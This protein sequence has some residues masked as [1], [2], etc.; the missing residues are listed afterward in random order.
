MGVSILAEKINKILENE[1]Y[2]SYES[3]DLSSDSYPPRGGLRVDGRIVPSFHDGLVCGNGL[4][5]AYV[6]IRQH[7]NKIYTSSISHLNGPNYAIKHFDEECHLPPPSSLWDPWGVGSDYLD[8]RP[9][10]DLML[11]YNYNGKNRFLPAWD[12]KNKWLRRLRSTSVVVTEA[13]DDEIQLR[14]VNFAPLEPHLPCLI[15]IVCAKNLTKEK[16]SN[17][18]CYAGFTLYRNLQ[19]A[20][21]DSSKKVLLARAS[22]AEEWDGMFLK[23]YYK[24]AFLVGSCPTFSSFTIGEEK[25]DA[26]KDSEDG[27]L[28]GKS[29]GKGYVNS[30]LEVNF[31]DVKPGEEKLAVLYF[32][33]GREY[34]EVTDVY[35]QL[36]K[37][38]VD[39]LLQKTIAIQKKWSPLSIETGNPRLNDLIDSIQNNIKQLQRD[40]G[41][42]ICG[43]RIFF[44]IW[45]E[46]AWVYV[47]SLLMLG[48]YDDTKGFMSYLHKKW[49]ELGVQINYWPLN[50]PERAL[51]LSFPYWP[52]THTMV[53]SYAILCARDFYYQTDDLDFIKKI[54]PMLEDCADT[55][56]ID[57]DGLSTMSG[58]TTVDYTIS[59][60]D[61]FAQFSE[62]CFLMVTAAD[63][64]SEIEKK[65]GRNGKAET[66]QK[67]AKRSRSAIEKLLWIDHRKHYALFRWHDGRVDE[68]PVSSVLI[69]P[70]LIG[71]SRA[72]DER[73]FNSVLEAWRYTRLEWYGVMKADP[74][75]HGMSG[76]NPIL[77]L[78]GMSAID[79]PK[80]G[81]YFNSLL[82]FISSVASVG[83]YHDIYNKAYCREHQ[84]NE[85][86]AAACLYHLTG[87][88]VDSEFVIFAPTLTKDN[89]YIRYSVLARGKQYLLIAKEDLLEISENEKRI[90]EC[91]HLVRVYLANN[92]YVF[93]P[94][95]CNTKLKKPMTITERGRKIDISIS[96]SWLNLRLSVSIGENILEISQSISKDLQFKIKNKSDHAVDL[97]LVFDK[98][99]VSVNLAKDDIYIL[100][101]KIGQELVFNVSGRDFAWNTL[102]IVEPNT[103]Y[104]LSGFVHNELGV[105]YD[106]PLIIKNERNSFKVRVNEG[107]FEQILTTKSVDQEVKLTTLRGESSFRM[108]VG[109]DYWSHL[110][111]ILAINGKANVAILVQDKSQKRIFMAKML[112]AE[113]YTLKNVSPPVFYGKLEEAKGNMHI[114]FVGEKSGISPHPTSEGKIV[115]NVGS[116]KDLQRVVEEMRRNIRYP[117]RFVPVPNPAKFG[118]LRNTLNKIGKTPSSLVEVLFEEVDGLR[119]FVNGREVNRKSRIPLSELS[120]DVNQEQNTVNLNIVKTGDRI[121]AFKITV[122]AKEPR[123]I[124]IRLMLPKEVL[125]VDGKYQFYLGNIK[126]GDDCILQSLNE[127]LSSEVEVVASVIPPKKK[128]LA[129]EVGE[130][131][132]IE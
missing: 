49:E 82:D 63:F 114:F 21:F 118:W 7:N 129:V 9:A 115:I 81:E 124:R 26:W 107:Y 127:D 22:G 14:T 121:R 24:K 112:L 72:N 33:T 41:A 64:M 60:S 106:G 98:R 48:K 102:D 58:D 123:K 31:G 69:R 101:E 117:P 86:L 35:A 6:G 119:T 27:V 34:N 44:G 10:H 126:L 90:V 65:L 71:Y 61:E 2:S 30:V 73:A 80:S 68:R 89:N 88:T 113:I 43:P 104:L 53:T 111:E 62:S 5:F 3:Y 29:S 122:H 38:D 120:E 109:R 132:E 37:F 16:I 17:L 32:V 19:E 85:F 59:R 20:N 130:L 93:E 77:G 105:P 96:P 1:S 8:S 92:K 74:T 100:K 76:T 42:F 50:G 99:E 75:S 47:K 45:W 40:E 128:I 91:D 131:P 87:F 110:D 52:N 28:A 56:Q 83:E 39:N 66:Y 108:T 125:R 97:R 11:F 70:E 103:S 46:D 18:K 51:G 84:R 67:M 15:R 12:M 95:I 13:T 55:Q 36:R 94:R 4:C 23:P 116:T 79:H 54:L 25:D 78:H 57:T